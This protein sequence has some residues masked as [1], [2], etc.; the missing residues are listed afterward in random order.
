MDHWS[1]LKNK[2]LLPE[3]YKLLFPESPLIF[4]S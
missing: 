2:R 1:T 3:P 4:N